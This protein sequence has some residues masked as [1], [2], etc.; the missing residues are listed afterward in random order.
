MTKFRLNLIKGQVPDYSQ[1]RRLYWGMHIYIL[2]TGLL[3]IIVSYRA[4]NEVVASCRI[5]EDANAVR[6][7]FRRV[8]GSSVRMDEYLQTVSAGLEEKIGALENLGSTLDGRLVVSPILSGI[9]LSLGSDMKLARFELKENNVDF[10]FDIAC[11]GSNA[12]TEVVSATLIEHWKA[13]TAIMAA[14]EEISPALVQKQL[15]GSSGAVL[16]KFTGTA[17]KGAP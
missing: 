8:Q 14:A 13:D 16:L 4:V 3:L 11:L 7:Q 12:A 10:E 1:R 9:A 5:A 2:L 15:L 6:S 17:R